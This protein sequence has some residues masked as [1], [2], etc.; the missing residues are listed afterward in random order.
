MDTG[1][2]VMNR[3]AKELNDIQYG[4]VKHEWAP[5]IEDEWMPL[6]MNVT[7][8]DLEKKNSFYVLNKR[9]LLAE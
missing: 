5:L 3:I 1:A 6:K 9:I 8:Q 2:K 7:N 4:R